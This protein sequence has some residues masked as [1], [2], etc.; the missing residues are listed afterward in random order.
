MPNP[1]VAHCVFCDDI[2]LERGNKISFMGVYTFDLATNVAFPVTLPKLA[3]TVWVIADI[4]DRPS[5]LEITVLLPDGKELLRAEVPDSSTP[6]YPDFML[7][8]AE[9]VILTSSFSLVP[10]VL[11]CEGTLEVWI[12]TERENLR[13]GRLWV[14]QIDMPE[15]TTQPSIA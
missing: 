9:R 5:K 15:P 13:A 14:H 10:V 3:I 6:S 1:R 4:S 8:S 11:P 2:R 7:G 12:E